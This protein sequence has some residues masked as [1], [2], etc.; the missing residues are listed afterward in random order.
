MTSTN[1]SNQGDPAEFFVKGFAL[2]QEGV[3]LFGKQAAGEVKD[4]GEQLRE[5]QARGAGRTHTA[6]RADAPPSEMTLILST[7]E[8][9]ALDLKAVR[10]IL[11]DGRHKA[12]MDETPG[13]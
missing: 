1:G 11:S 10:Q 3:K 4:L 6:R 9:M 13:S 7:L 8:D 5:R 2:F 12:F